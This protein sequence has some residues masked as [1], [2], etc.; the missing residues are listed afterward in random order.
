[1][2]NMSKT[3]THFRDVVT[4]PSYKLLSRA[5]AVLT[6]EVQAKISMAGKASFVSLRLALVD[7]P[8]KP[9]EPQQ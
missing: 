3:R 6:A 2:I 8:L 5:E 7:Q 4:S 1:M 9:S